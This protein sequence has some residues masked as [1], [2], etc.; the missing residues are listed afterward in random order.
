MNKITLLLF[1]LIW[2]SIAY[3]QD[4]ILLRNGSEIKCKMDMIG[5]GIIFYKENGN[6]LQLPTT[7]VYMIKYAK[8][9]N[10]FFNTDGEANYNT[11]QSF[12]KL[13]KKDIAIYLCEGGE[14]I[15]SEVSITNEDINYR[16]QSNKPTAFLSS[17]KSNDWITIAKDNVFLIRYFDGTREVINDLQKLEALPK[18]KFPFVP[19][20]KDPSLPRPADIILYRGITLSV[21]IYDL[22]DENIYYRKKEWQDGP[23]FRI[24]RNK[25]NKLTYK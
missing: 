20:S 15:A 14:I 5:N 9:G 24:N 7:Q 6:N 22:G 18:V 16:A 25:I 2:S 11:E 17:K 13:G 12:A 8:R 19:V 1:M 3:A 23:I 10:T 21:I 4:M